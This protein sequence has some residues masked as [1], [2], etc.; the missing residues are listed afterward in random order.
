[1]HRSG[2]VDTAQRCQDPLYCIMIHTGAVA[3]AGPWAVE[4]G[5]VRHNLLT[6]APQPHATVPVDQ[7][8]HPRQPA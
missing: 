3:P 2:N 6:P 8:R 1:M 4:A 5:P 7:V